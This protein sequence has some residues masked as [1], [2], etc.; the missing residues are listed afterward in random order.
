MIVAGSAHPFVFGFPAAAAAAA[1]CVSPDA[2]A[3][4]DAVA[5]EDN[6]HECG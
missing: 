4:A 2:V 5:Y 1:L 3:V 6:F